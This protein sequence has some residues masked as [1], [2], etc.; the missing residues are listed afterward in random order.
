MV[1]L[2]AQLTAAQ[3]IPGVQEC[4]QQVEEA[5][6]TGYG[7]SGYVTKVRGG[8]Q[9]ARQLQDVRPG[10]AALLVAAGDPF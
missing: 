4:D 6:S 5:F 2:F 3:P 10:A 8:T 1:D 7:H 9:E